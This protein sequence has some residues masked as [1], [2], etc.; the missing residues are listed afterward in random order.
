M[1]SVKVPTSDSY[2]DYLILRLRDPEEAAAYIEAILEEPEPEPELLRSAL[3]DVL[4][5][6][7]Q[8]GFSVEQKQ[9]YQQQLEQIL[10][11]TG[12]T[13]ISELANWLHRLGLKLTIVAPDDQFISNQAIELSAT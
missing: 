7:G 2:H 8:T 5:A 4:E 1:S 11:S 12:S 6:L 13:A 9:V 10:S 3:Q